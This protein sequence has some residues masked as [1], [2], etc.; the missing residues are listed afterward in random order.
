MSIG[1]DFRG[2]WLGQYIYDPSPFFQQP[3]PAVSFTLTLKKTWLGKLR[4]RVQDDP[5]NGMPEPGIVQG[6]VRGLEIEFVKLMPVCYMNLKGEMVPLAQYLRV[7]HDLPHPPIYYHGSYMPDEDIVR[8]T[9]ELREQVIRLPI[10]GGVIGR[11]LRRMTGTWEMRRH[12][13]AIVGK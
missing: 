12:A 3:M 7:D 11:K 2:R 5:Q 4:G 9:W 1:W 13:D 10:G 6:I 8:G